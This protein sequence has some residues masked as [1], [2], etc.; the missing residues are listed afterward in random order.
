MRIYVGNLSYQ[1][2]DEALRAAF[3]AHGS[4]G[5]AEV[6]RDRESG[7]TKGFGFV[8]MAAPDEATKAMAA[9]NGSELDGRELLVNEARP[10]G[11]GAGRRVQ[12]GRRGFDRGPRF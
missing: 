10:R 8:E 1:T 6:V 2:S 3:S 12:P 11:E 4:V 5:S 7:V 9:L